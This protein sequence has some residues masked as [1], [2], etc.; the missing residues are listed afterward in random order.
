[1]VPIT[2]V[3]LCVACMI[4]VIILCRILTEEFRYLSVRIAE[5]VPKFD[6]DNSDLKEFA[7]CV[8]LML[9]VFG[10]VVVVFR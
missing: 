1:M 2:F 8:V 7:F 6:G 9:F 4:F 10:L 5:L 3:L